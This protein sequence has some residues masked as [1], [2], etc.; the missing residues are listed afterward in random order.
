[1]F[2]GA[3]AFNQ[4]LCSWKALLDPQTDVLDMFQSTDCAVTN[5]PVV[6]NGSSFCAVC[7]NLS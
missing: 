2:Y 3:A 4:S 6:A 5:D 1:M 7:G